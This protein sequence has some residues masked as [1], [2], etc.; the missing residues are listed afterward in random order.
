MSELMYPAERY[1]LVCVLL[2]CRRRQI[3]HR[4][5]VPP[6]KKACRYRYVHQLER[7]HRAPADAAEDGR[8]A[9]SLRAYRL[10]IGQPAHQRR[11]P[12]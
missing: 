8:R 3:K 6:P 5:Q 9:L 4:K 10:L 12:N 7:T 1:A 11:R 2:S